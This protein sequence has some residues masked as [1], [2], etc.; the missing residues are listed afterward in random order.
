M[1]F[2]NNSRVLFCNILKEDSFT[3]KF[4]IVVELTE[5][6]AADAEAAGLTV[7]TKEYD[8]KPQFQVTFKSKY[9]APVVDSMTKP[10]DLR[11]QE[12]GRGS[13]VNVKYSFRDWTSPCK[14]ETGTAS[15][16]SAVQLVTLKEAGAG[17]F[18]EVAAG[19]SEAG[20]Y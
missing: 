11:G 16:L 13:I 12:I 10:Y 19:S 1:P 17:G 2:L 15:D 9:P 8:S 6:D 3:Q 18:E 20:D 4:Q 14:T 5:D 7:K